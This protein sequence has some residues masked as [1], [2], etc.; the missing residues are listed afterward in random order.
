MIKL[1]YLD[2]YIEKK[3][4]AE[5][6]TKRADHEPSGKLSAS[7][8]NYPTQHQVLHVIGVP[9][10]P[11]GEYTVRKFKRGNHVEDW[12]R[13]YMPGIVGK[14]KFV[15]YR[16]VVGFA[17]AVVDMRDWNLDIVQETIPHEIKSV[18]NANFKWILKDG[19]KEGHA[20]QGALYALALGTKWFAIDYVATDDY[21]VETFLIETAEFQKK[22]DESIDVFD[23]CIKSKTVPVFE[24][25]EAWQANVKYN[26]Y[27]EWVS[28][29]PTEIEIKLQ[30]E[31][32]EAYANLKG[33]KTESRY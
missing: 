27:S 13:G 4:I 28:L 1:S 21:R 9:S 18:S 33:E 12:V 19:F 7:K 31:Y 14:E 10:D 11:L 23:A 3:L 5:D 6:D 2:N 26:S 32:P 29:T 20:M 30:T 22:V 24:A 16:N 8:L 15:E 25:K 17:D